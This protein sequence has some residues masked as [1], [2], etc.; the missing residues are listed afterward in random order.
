MEHSLISPVEISINRDKINDPNIISTL[1]THSPLA[2]SLM[3]YRLS[4]Q[5]QTQG[6]Q[7]PLSLA[8][9]QFNPNSSSHNKLSSSLHES[10]PSNIPM[11]TPTARDHVTRY[12]N[13]SNGIIQSEI[14]FEKLKVTKLKNDLLDDLRVEIKDIIKKELESL[15]TIWTCSATNYITEIEALKREL[16]IKERMIAQLLNTLK[17]IFTVNIAQSAKPGSVFTCESETKA[18]NISGMKTNQ[19]ER[20]RSIDVISN[21]NIVTNSQALKLSLSEQMKN[22]KCQKKE[23]FDQFK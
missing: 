14:M 11:D 4:I 19:T 13:N 6:I 18:N 23:D 5:T 15:H 16:D 20:K 1:S 8:T 3:T 10:S 9:P 22:V 17:E 21:G 7:T 2:A 12:S